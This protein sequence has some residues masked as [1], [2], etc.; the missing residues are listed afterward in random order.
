MCF[1]SMCYMYLYF[2]NACSLVRTPEDGSG[3]AL[4]IDGQRLLAPSSCWAADDSLEP[5][6]TVKH[7][8]LCFMQI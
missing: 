7:F 3:S 1:V 4:C 2:G 6:L 8:S 5:A